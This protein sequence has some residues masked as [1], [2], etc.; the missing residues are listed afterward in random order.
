MLR[1]KVRIEQLLTQ[2]A[3][4]F[5]MLIDPVNV[6]FKTRDEA[7]VFMTGYKRKQREWQSVESN[8][9]T[10]PVLQKL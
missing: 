3:R 10:P 9:A 8:R 2:G 4:A 7:D 5:M 1:D 6:K